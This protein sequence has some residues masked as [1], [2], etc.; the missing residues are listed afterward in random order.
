MSPSRKDLAWDL[1]AFL[2]RWSLG[3]LFIYM[4]FNKAM[5]PFDFLKLVREYDLVSS[6]FLLNSIAAALPWFEI[7]CGLLL[8][9]GVGVRGSALLLFLMLV[10]FT[11]VV[12]QRALAIAHTQ[13]KPFCAISFDCGC[14]NGEVLICHKLVENSCLILLALWLILTRH[15]RRWALRFQLRPA[16][17]PSVTPARPPHASAPRTPSLP[18]P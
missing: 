12:L 1:A 15:G 18:H 9:L 13:G 4:G 14:G 8:L 5:H 7:Y 17:A 2:A 6:P 3:V 16:A 11:L 10:P